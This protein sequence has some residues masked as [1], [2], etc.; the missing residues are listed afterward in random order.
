MRRIACKCIRINV[1]CRWNIACDAPLNMKKKKRTKTETKTNQKDQ[2]QEREKQREKERE[3][4]YLHLADRRMMVHVRHSCA[5]RAAR[6]GVSTWYICTHTHTH[7]YTHMPTCTCRENVQDR[8]TL[9]EWLLKGG[10]GGDGMVVEYRKLPAWCKRKGQTCF[11]VVFLCV[12]EHMAVLFW[13]WSLKTRPVFLGLEVASHCKSGIVCTSF[14]N[15]YLT[16]DEVWVRIRDTARVRINSRVGIRIIIIIRIRMGHTWKHR[17]PWMRCRC[18]V[19]L[20]MLDFDVPR[21]SV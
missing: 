21:H 11:W 5:L 1:I 4:G 7:T 19:F 6:L 20:Q 16:V 13:K 18:I 9:D 15:G 2:D 17:T 14:W 12:W 3:R 8:F 10:G